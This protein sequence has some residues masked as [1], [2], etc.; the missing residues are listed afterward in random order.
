M[1]NISILNRDV[2][3][4]S[5][6]CHRISS[7]GTIGDISKNVVSKIIE[8]FDELKN[9]GKS[10]SNL[11]GLREVVEIVRNRTLVKMRILKKHENGGYI[12]VSG[13]TVVGIVSVG[14]IIFMA[15]KF[16]LRG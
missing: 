13:I 3:L 2:N 8:C 6:I 11:N 9:S 16:I 10:I 15:I 5:D 12:L 14:A 7:K 4:R 1:E